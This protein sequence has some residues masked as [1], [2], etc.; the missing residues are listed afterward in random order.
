MG[1][2]R[3]LPVQ[4]LLSTNHITFDELFTIVNFDLRNSYFC[5]GDT[6]LKQIIGMPMGSP[7]SPALAQIV[8]AYYETKMHAK[9]TGNNPVEGV[10][11]VDDLTAFIYYV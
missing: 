10:R 6:L 7:V 1:Y 2:L 4:R 8:C 3:T 5:V 11:Y 9:N